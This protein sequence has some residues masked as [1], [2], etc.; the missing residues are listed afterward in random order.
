MRRLQEKLTYANVISTLCL[1]LLLGGGTAYAAA[2]LGKN[3]VGTKQLKPAAVTPAKLSKAAKATLTGAPGPAGPQGD[4]GAPGKK[5][6]KG[7]RGEKGDTGA[8]GDRGERG[9]PG[10]RGTSNAVTKFISGAVPWSNPFATIASVNLEAGSWA[11]TS[12][13]QAVNFE[14]SAQGAECRLLVGTT[15]VDES[16]ELFLA[17]FPQPGAKQPVALTG[18]ATVAAPTTAELQCEAVFANGHVVNPAITAI[19][20]DDVKTE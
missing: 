18:A 17:A 3:S 19:E 10:P 13:A 16:G 9:E 2:Q 6:E 7:A 8:K 5:G 20:V 15:T 14:S 4:T 12:T 1:V 11:V